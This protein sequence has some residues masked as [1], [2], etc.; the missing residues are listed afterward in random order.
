MPLALPA[1]VTLFLVLWYICTGV[2]VGRLRGKLKITA[3]AV[4]GDPVFE[5]AYRVQM[6]ELEQLA[7]FLPGMWIFATFGNPRYAAIAGV[8]YLIGR[9]M[10]ALGYWAAAEKRSLGFAVASVA[11]AVTWVAALVSVVRVLSL[12]G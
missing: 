6:N 12:G 2:K 4:I 7:A 1:L 9:V 3:P 10:Y 11:G 5:R 8:V